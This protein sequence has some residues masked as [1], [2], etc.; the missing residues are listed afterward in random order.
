MNQAERCPWPCVIRLCCSLYG[1][2][3]NE[4]GAFHVPRLFS[5]WIVLLGLL[6][7]SLNF[8]LIRCIDIDDYPEASEA[9]EASEACYYRCLW[10]YHPERVPANLDHPHPH[11]RSL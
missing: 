5:K 6:F 3:E 7:C 11:L 9:S 4:F 8:P 10:R 2:Y 1:A